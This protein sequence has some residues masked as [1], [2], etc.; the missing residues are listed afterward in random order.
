MFRVF[1]YCRVSTTGQTVENQIREI[2]SAG[3]N[4]DPR[5]IVS[6][7]VS[8][9]TASAQRTGFMKLADRLEA[10]DVLVVTKLDR[11]GRNLL[12]IRQTVDR[13]AKLGV[14][15]HCLQLG[16]MDLTSAGGKMIMGV[17]GAFAEF[18]RDLLIERT[19]SGLSRA[20]SQGKALG[21]KA[22]LSAKDKE[23]VQAGIAGGASVSAL[24]KMHGV[25]RLTIA[26]ARD[27]ALEAV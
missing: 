7:T 23:A 26:R 5:R 4:I 1:A 11:L 13:L 6:E 19:Q 22:L 20:K 10:D 2:E 18:E 15:L 17:M 3:F 21:R 14:R 8:G 12:D 24:A 9:S 16:G 27:E 25:S